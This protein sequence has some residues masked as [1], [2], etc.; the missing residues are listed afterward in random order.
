MRNTPA[1]LHCGAM[2]AHQPPRRGSHR[3]LF[4]AM[5]KLIK[6][7]KGVGPLLRHRSQFVRP[8]KRRQIEPATHGVVRLNHFVRPERL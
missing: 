1:E 8:P 4:R 7:E 2:R 3:R 6:G 5:D